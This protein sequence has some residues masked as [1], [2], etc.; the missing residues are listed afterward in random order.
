[1]NNFP[2]DIFEGFD[3]SEDEVTHFRN[4]HVGFCRIDMNRLS[5]LL[6][7][8]LTSISKH[9]TYNSFSITDVIQELEGVG[10]GCKQRF[11]QFKYLPLKGLFK[12][13]FFDARFMARNLI[14]HWGLEFENSHKFNSLFSRVTEEEEKNPSRFGWQGRLAHEMTVGGYEERAK[15]NKRTGEWII[16]AKH[17]NLNYYLCISRHSKSKPE[18]QEIYDFLKLL[19]KNEYPFLLSGEAV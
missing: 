14:N 17:N 5:Q 9:R 3:V 18:D 8:Q 13:H 1:M 6:L 19:C 12:A 2:T 7:I 10:R 16:F 15:K 4:N 11:E